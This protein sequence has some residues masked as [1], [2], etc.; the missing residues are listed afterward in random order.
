VS[1]AHSIHFAAAALVNWALKLWPVPLVAAAALIA[2]L[3]A[4][5]F[6]LQHEYVDAARAAILRRMQQRATTASIAAIAIGALL[7]MTSLYGL[8]GQGS[9]LASVAGFVLVLA[10]AGMLIA[11]Q[12]PLAFK[13]PHAGVITIFALAAILHGIECFGEGPSGARVA[14]YVWGMTPYGLCLAISCLGTLRTAPA[15]G[16]AL[17]LGVDVLVHREVFMAPQGS[18]SGLLLIFVPFWHNL[19]IVPAGTIVAWLVLRRRSQSA[20]LQP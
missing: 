5:R 7:F 14:F 11:A 3:A 10:G 16:G 13:R 20:E 18:T 8:L 6:G 1:T 19:V 4:Q 15:I 17:A 12:K 9:G 2:M